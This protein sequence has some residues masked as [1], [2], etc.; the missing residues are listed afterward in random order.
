[1][2]KNEYI[3]YILNVLTNILSHYRATHGDSSI[4]RNDNIGEKLCELIAI[5]F[6]CNRLKGLKRFYPDASGLYPLWLIF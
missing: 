4:L 1:M 6:S 3:E 5:N 2:E